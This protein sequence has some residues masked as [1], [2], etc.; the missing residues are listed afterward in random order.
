MDVMDRLRCCI[1]ESRRIQDLVSVTL[2]EYATL[3]SFK[4]ILLRVALMLNCNKLKVVF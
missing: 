3:D 2:C 1:C 4:I